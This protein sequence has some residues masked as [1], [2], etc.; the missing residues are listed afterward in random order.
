MP[1]SLPGVVRNP[2]PAEAADRA[3]D[4]GADKEGPPG[5]RGG[6]SVPRVAEEAIVRRG[7]Q[8]AAPIEHAPNG[9]A[10]QS[11]SQPTPFLAIDTDGHT[12][13]HGRRDHP[14]VCCR[15][16]D[17]MDCTASMG[18]QPLIERTPALAIEDLDA[19]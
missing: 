2:Q 4:D 18:S 14:L 1:A 11:R 5:R 6:P 16:T 12:V 10:R 19:L 3:D 17:D 7:Q 9:P 8:P 13:Q 15:H